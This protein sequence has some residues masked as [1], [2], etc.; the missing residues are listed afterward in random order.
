[1]V[2]RAS[3]R[4]FQVTPHG[5][6]EERARRIRKPR[7]AVHKKAA[8]GKENAGILRSAHVFG[9]DAAGEDFPLRSVSSP[10]F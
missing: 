10:S 8:V 6:E 7:S 4:N 2:G 3:G 9:K 1:M 5:R